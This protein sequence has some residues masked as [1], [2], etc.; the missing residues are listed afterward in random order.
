MCA[1]LDTE[2][3]LGKNLLIVNSHLSCCASNEDRQQQVDEFL[4]VWREWISNG[5]GPFDLEDET[6]FIH[7]GDYN[8]VGYRQQMKTIRIGDI[9]DE[10]EYGV[11]FLPD[12]DSTAIVDLFSRHTHKRMG[13]TW[14]KDGS[15]FNPGKLDYIFYS[16]AT[17]DTGRHFTLNT[18]AMEEATLTEYGLEW[19]DTQEASDHLPR[20]FDISLDPSVGI[21]DENPISTKF[22]M[23]YN[24]PNP[25]NP[26]TTISINI[27][28]TVH[29]TSLHIYNIS[30]R[31]IETLTAGE[32]KPGNHEFQWN[33]TYHPSGVY[34]IKF[35]T[36]NYS[37]TRKMV[38]LK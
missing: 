38:L 4:S 30:G 1:L 29:A 20:I 34:F 21:Q 12:W 31:C 33:G 3:E 22:A 19:D 26:T 32:L 10:N 25:F 7:V 27:V 8:F 35:S 13:Y 17:I 36:G 9:E 24:Y 6:P 14:R 37:Q 15:S 5:N 28:K 11:D 18:L 2:E 23:F 16:D